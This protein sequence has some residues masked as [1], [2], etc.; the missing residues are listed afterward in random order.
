MIKMMNDIIDFLKFGN[1]KFLLFN[2]NAL[3]IG[4]SGYLLIYALCLIFNKNIF[5]EFLIPLGVIYLLFLNTLYYLYW[6]LLGFLHQKKILTIN[7][8]KVRYFNF[9]KFTMIS[10]N[11]TII[12]II[13]IEIFVPQ[14]GIIIENIFK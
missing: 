12:I 1:S 6:L 7:I 8:S 5:L 14:L 2:R 3:L 4:I 13:F 11:L 9:I 10:A